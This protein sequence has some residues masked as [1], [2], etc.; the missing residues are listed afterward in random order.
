MSGGQPQS[1][2]PAF[3]ATKK[4]DHLL[5]K[6]DRVDVAI[7][8]AGPTGLTLACALLERG[9]NVRVFDAATQ[10]ATT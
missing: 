7:A 5:D 3:G 8:G 4:R 2:C 1:R 10:P 9:V 6:F